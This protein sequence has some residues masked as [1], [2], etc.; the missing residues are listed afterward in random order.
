MTLN[1]PVTLLYDL[2][3]IQQIKMEGAEYVPN[4]YEQQLE[5]FEVLKLR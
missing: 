3:A 1:M 4:A 2:I 5:L